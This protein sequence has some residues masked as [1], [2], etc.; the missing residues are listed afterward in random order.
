[1]KPISI[2]RLG[3]LLTD[4]VGSEARDRIKALLVR[5]PAEEP[6]KALRAVLRLRHLRDHPELH[7]IYAEGMIID[8]VMRRIIEPDS[9]CVDVGCHVGSTLSE[10]LRLAPHGRHAAFEPIPSKAARLRRRFPE[11]SVFDVALADA[12]GEAT[13]FVHTKQ[14]GFSGLHRHGDDGEHEAVTVRTARLDEIMAHQRI[15]FIKLDVEGG[16]LA[17]L[18]GAAGVLERARPR[19][20]FECTQTSVRAHG[21]TAED[22][23]DWLAAHGYA[24]WQPSGFLARTPPLDRDRFVAAQTYPFQA[25]NF[26][27]QP[28]DVPC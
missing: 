8:R 19:I 15:D 16:E 25:F 26:F 6:L 4:L 10:L 2:P 23:F 28:A 11:V 13:F 17:V 18:K 24:V 1:M 3:G 9:C 22:V 12:D 27:A 5:T 14:S 7:A 20:L 21:V